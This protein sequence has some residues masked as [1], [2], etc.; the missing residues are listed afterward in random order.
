MEEVKA[1]K[2]EVEEV[3]DL[4]EVNAERIEALED[5][6]KIYKSILVDISEFIDPMTRDRVREDRRSVV[7]VIS[8][9]IRKQLQGQVD[10]LEANLNERFNQL[11]YQVREHIV[12][13]N[14]KVN[15]LNEAAERSQTR[16][17]N[18]QDKILNI[19]A[20]I[21]KLA[22]SLENLQREID[23]KATLRELAQMAER[24]QYYTPLNGFEKL[25]VETSIK[26]NRDDFD[27]LTDEVKGIR[28]SLANYLPVTKEAELLSESAARVEKQ[29][30][31]YSTIGDLAGL[32]T[33]VHERFLEYR[34]DTLENFD[35]CKERDKLIKSD[36]DVLRDL[37]QRKPWTADLKPI[38]KDLGKRATKREL[39]S[40]R[41][42]SMPA[43]AESFRKINE[44]KSELASFDRSLGRFD[45]IICEK[46]SKE[47]IAEVKKSIKGFLDE[48]KF[49]EKVKEFDEKFRLTEMKSSSIVEEMSPIHAKIDNLH[50][51]L[52]SQKQESR[53]YKLVY[54][55]LMDLRDRVDSKADLSDLVKIA[56]QSALWSDAQVLK[57][58]SELMRRQVESTAVL[59]ASLARTLLK[60][61]DTPSVKYRRRAEVYRLLLSLLDWIKANKTAGIPEELVEFEGYEEPSLRT[62][63][64][65]KTIKKNQSH[66]IGLEL[67]KP[68]SGF[69]TNRRKST[70][71][72]RTPRDLPPIKV[73]NP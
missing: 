73:Y 41:N 16:E 71:A 58:Q 43:I 21:E 37:V 2:D 66:E 48:S 45:E 64:T 12:D 38:M 39:E 13:A 36:V 28:L 27:M 5:F 8:N 65:I 42:D 4:V 14:E 23:A 33:E 62:P 44:L 31:N 54:N 57:Q 50:F 49:T 40:L 60:D 3:R 51:Q 68:K 17:L 52:N 32:R 26:A 56:E 1:I 72:P 46:A 25:Q 6:S 67:L 18:F 34:Q 70:S 59:S 10:E 15:K 35:F 63:R 11:S 55:T 20:Y 29:L 47:D 30:E 24:F 53:D 61:I 9:E 19:D 22:G 69:T 7:F